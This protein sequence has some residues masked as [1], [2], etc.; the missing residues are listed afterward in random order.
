MAALDLA[1]HLH[2]T[3]DF[4]H[5]SLVNDLNALS[6]EQATGSPNPALRAAIKL[7]AECGS[8]N[9]LL[10]SLIAGEAAARPTPEQR[11][12]YFAGITT[13]AE[14][15]AALDA[16]TQK[17]K[18]AIDALPTEKWGETVPT[19]LGEMTKLG[20]AS[21]AATHMMYHDGQLNQV[22]LLHGDTEMHW[23]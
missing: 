16:G 8:V 23:N 12:A 18:A 20:A 2:A 9:G 17:L 22:H 21:F 15:I 1:V 10:A 13:R 19:P 14:A 6:E 7:V 11:E 4:A 5:K 3:T